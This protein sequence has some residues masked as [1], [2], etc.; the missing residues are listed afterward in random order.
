[1]QNAELRMQN[2]LKFFRLAHRLVVI[3]F[4]CFVA[5]LPVIA[6]F[7]LLLNSYLHAAVGISGGMVD[8][9]PGL[10]YF[11]GVLLRLPIPAFYFLLAVSA[12]LFGPLLLGLHA[13]AGRMVLGQHVWLSEFF[14][15]ARRNLRQGAALG[16]ILVVAG[17]LMLWNVFGGLTSDGAWIGFLIVVSRWVSV[18]LFLMAGI[19]LPFVCQVAVTMEQPLWIV[20][21]NGVIL[22]R[23]RLLRG[24]FV[25]LTIAGYWWVT[26][27][28][29][30]WL[31]LVA[32]PLVSIAIPALVQAWV[33][34]PV[35]EKYLVE[36]RRRMNETV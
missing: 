8:I 1:M 11:A 25:L 18:G 36:P 34:R 21:K 20:V 30:P 14:A 35:V 28:T 12:V 17:Q 24:G 13:V 6:W 32:L 5:F 27:V 33:C 16:L 2:F 10:G 29:V 23:V 22:A 19:S 31:S 9:L 4:V 26:T 3:N 15:E 7:Y